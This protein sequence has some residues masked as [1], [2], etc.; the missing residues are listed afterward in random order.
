MSR[1]GCLLVI[2]VLIGA[3]SACSMHPPAPSGEV[4]GTSRRSLSLGD[5]VGSEGR[6]GGHEWRGLPF[7]RPPTGE[8]RWRV[9]QPPEPWSG[10]REVVANPPVCMQIANISGGVDGADS[11]EPTGSEDC[12]YLN[13]FAPR[14]DPDAVPQEGERL[15]VMFWIHGGGNTIGDV[16]MYNGGKLATEYGVVVV[17]MQYRLGPFGW[18]RHPALRSQG[19]SDDGRS[20][21]FGTLDMIAALEFVNE[22]IAAFGGDPDNVTIFGESAGGR[23]VVTLL[24]AP[25]AGGLF[26]RAIVQSGS[27]RRGDLAEA[28]N[29]VDASPP[30]HV[31]SSR[32]VVLSLLVAEGTAAD[33]AEA[34]S[35]A[36]TMDDGEAARFLRSRDA[37]AVLKAYPER[38][39]GM[40]D[41]PQIFGDGHVLSSGTTFEAFDAG[42]YHRVPL[43]LGTTRDEGKTFQLGNSELVE[44][45]FGFLPT[46][47]DWDRYD[48]EAEYG[49]KSWKALGVDEL[50]RRARRVQGA[51]VYA[52]RFD[53]DEEP[54]RLFVLDFSRLLGAAHGLDVFFVFGDWEVGSVGIP[55]FAGENEASRTLLSDRM[56]S[57]WAEFAHS[58]RPGTGRAGELPEWTA[59][60]PDPETTASLMLLD[61]EAGGGLRMVAETVDGASIA[62][63][64]AADARFPDDAARCAYL[65]SDRRLRTGPRPYLSESDLVPF[66]AS[67]AGVQ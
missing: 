47:R 16:S 17:A 24:T 44:M 21:N 65:R 2:P 14:F 37:G 51:S 11:G 43:M 9:P 3:L 33:R 56:M 1:R 38:A 41:V 28:E 15:P 58:G 60:A 26:H 59:W 27:S 36:E 7:A 12:L 40:L 61:S 18:F 67:L 53:W 62:A 42:N 54:T 64:I 66:C 50:A 20:G 29:Y 13:I 25:S 39:F 35:I 19:A 30:G 55:F 34:R 5:V 31:S 4:D 63:D 10:L 6:F 22:H 49:A 52:Y 46:V 57:Y 48:R 23:N 32:E 45:R 8:H